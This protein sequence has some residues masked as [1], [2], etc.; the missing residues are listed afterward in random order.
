M[1]KIRIA[2]S[3]VISVYKN[4][5]RHHYARLIRTETIAY[6]DEEVV[7]SFDLGIGGYNLKERPERISVPVSKEVLSSPNFS[8]QLKRQ[9][10]AGGTLLKVTLINTKT[11]RKFE[12]ESYSRRVKQSAVSGTIQT[13]LKF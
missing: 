1:E 5:H 8:L 11:E 2:A 12:E 9:Y 4:H 6:N 10:R 7:I 3:P 13:T